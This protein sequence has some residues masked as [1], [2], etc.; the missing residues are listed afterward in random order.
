MYNGLTG[1]CHVQFT[2]VPEHTYEYLEKE[3][4]QC[5]H[6]SKIQARLPEVQVGVK[7][8]HKCLPFVSKH[9]QPNTRQ[10]TA[11]RVQ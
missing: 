3:K 6:T 8:T 9:T 11:A 2:I 10:H 7:I 4:A 5:V 1:K